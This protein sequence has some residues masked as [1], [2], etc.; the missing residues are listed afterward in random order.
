MPVGFVSHGAPPLALDHEKGRDLR[1]WADALPR[2]AAVLVVSAHWDHTP[3][4]VG[5]ASTR[6][7]LYDFGGFPD[8]L[9]RLEYPAPGA[10]ELATRVAERLDAGRDDDR[11]WDHGVWVPLLHMYPDADVPVL[12]VSLPGRLPARELL[13]LGARLAP[14]R[15]EGVLV[16]GSGGAVHNLRELDWRD[17]SPP[18][19]WATDFEQWATAA[20]RAGDLDRLASFRDVPS[21]R[22]AHPTPEHFQPLLVAAG[23]ASRG[24]HDASFP[25][26]GFE[27]GSLSRLA[28]QLG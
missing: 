3:V 23:A 26:E 25:V 10:P 22:L 21:S 17:E 12:Q 1:R 15:D 7:L 20:L 27:Y 4:R 5:T 16:L 2:P 8:E 19:A 28:V 9:R 18:P 11:P 13:E 6:P 24:T 14:L